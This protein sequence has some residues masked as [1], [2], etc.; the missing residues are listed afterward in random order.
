MVFNKKIM[1]DGILCSQRLSNFEND[2]IYIKF[3]MEIK[4]MCSNV[5]EMVYM[6]FNGMPQSI[7]TGDK[8]FVY[9]YETNI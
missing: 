5:L 2:R 1:C 8:L 9:D 7:I 6:A 3:S 4:I